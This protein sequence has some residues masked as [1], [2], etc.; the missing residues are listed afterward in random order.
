LPANDEFEHHETDTQ[1]DADR[2]GPTIV[3]GSVAVSVSMSVSGTVAVFL[4]RA[5]IDT[6]ELVMVRRIVLIVMVIARVMIVAT[7]AMRM[8]VMIVMRMCGR[9]MIMIMTRCI[10]RRTRWDRTSAATMTKVIIAVHEC[11]ITSVGVMGTDAGAVTRG[12]TMRQSQSMPGHRQGRAVRHIKLRS[13][14]LHRKFLCE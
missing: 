12:C 3:R 6:W 9:G 4:A 14:N 1:S 13:S 11:A 8:M 10:R 7:A 2:E 5:Q